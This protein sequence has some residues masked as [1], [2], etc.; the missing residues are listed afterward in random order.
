MDLDG[1]HLRDPA[2]PDGLAYGRALLER[3]AYAETLRAVAASEGI[4]AARSDA[5]RREIVRRFT[6]PDYGW[7]W[8][9][10]RAVRG[11]IHQTITAIEREYSGGGNPHEHRDEDRKGRAPQG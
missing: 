5:L 10:P 8:P 7:M 9:F 11:W 3:E 6:G 4:L 2:A 1:D